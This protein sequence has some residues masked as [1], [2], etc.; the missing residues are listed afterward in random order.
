MA[1]ERRHFLQAITT[2]AAA[3]TLANGATPPLPSVSKSEHGVSFGWA[4]EGESYRMAQFIVDDEKIKRPF[5]ANVCFPFSTHQLTRNFPVQAGDPDDHPTMHPGIWLAFGDLSGHDFWRNKGRV[6]FEKY[7]DQAGPVQSFAA[8]F[9]Y[10]TADGKP[11]ARETF[12]CN[13]SRTSDLVKLRDFSRLTDPAKRLTWDSTIEALDRDL[14]FGDQEEMGLGVRVATDMT[15]KNG[16]SILDSE[17]RKGEKEIW[18][19]TADW[20]RYGKPAK[21]LLLMAHP[22]NFRRSAWHVRDYGLM[23][24]NPFADK[25]FDPQKAPAKTVV[26]AGESLR[27]RFAIAMISDREF[28]PAAEFK[29]YVA[30]SKR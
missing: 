24:A 18:G 3:A 28:D 14:V 5:F 7:V 20:C 6:V 15:V 25:A 17:G 11:L 13:F 29:A 22:D 8:A 19:K 1:I 4:N 23:V 16:G 26:K 12:R 10:E 21:A 27:L 30:D 2:T 9:R